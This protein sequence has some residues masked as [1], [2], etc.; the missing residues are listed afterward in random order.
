M[1]GKRL[2]VVCQCQTNPQQKQS[3]V[4]EK[5]CPELP[6][7]FENQQL[8]HLSPQ[9]S[10]LERGMLLPLPRVNLENLLVCKNGRAFQ[11]SKAGQVGSVLVACRTEQAKRPDANKMTPD[12]TSSF[13]PEHECILANLSNSSIGASFDQEIG[14]L[15]TTAS[16]DT[17][18]SR[19]EKHSSA[20]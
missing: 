16:R 3:G 15:S 18:Q 19:N 11:T 10:T 17:R 9:K 4:G 13:Q 14:E 6:T 7:A 5:A 12:K 20:R 8:Q 1:S 2:N